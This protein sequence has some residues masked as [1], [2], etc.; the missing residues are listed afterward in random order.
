M[1]S[2]SRIVWQT[3][4]TRKDEMSYLTSQPVKLVDRLKLV[5]QSE[6]M[7]NAGVLAL[8]ILYCLLYASVRLSISSSMELD[9]AEQFLD[10]AAFHLGYKEQAPLYT[11]IYWLA[12]LVGGNNLVTLTVVKY[13]LIFSFFAIFYLLV[14]SFWG[15][16]ESLVVTGSLL[17]FPTYS[18]E[19]NRDLSHSILIALMA[20]LTCLFFVRS[21]RERATRDYVAMGI[22]CGLGILSK[23]NFAI[24]L[25]AFL[26]A[27]LS[28]PKLRRFFFDRKIVFSV[29]ACAALIA[30][31]FLWLFHENFPSLQFAMQVSHS[32]DLKV[33]S[34]PRS[35]SVI[36]A[37]YAEIFAFVLVIVLFFQRDF[38]K[39]IS[40][41][42]PA[43]LIF[44]RMAL[45]GLCLPIIG[46]ILFKCDTFRSR[47]LSTV[48]F[49]IPIAF[50]SMMNP[51]VNESRFRAFG[52]LTV[53]IA[54][55]VLCIRLV[56]GFFPDRTGKIERIHI[57]YNALS[58]Q[59]SSKL[60]KMGFSSLR[61]VPFIAD[62]SNE[63]LAANFLAEM[64]STRF[65]SLTDC[66]T[67]TEVQKTIG[68]KGGIYITGISKGGATVPDKFSSYFPQAVKTTLAST[69]LHSSKS[70]MVQ[71]LIIRPSKVTAG[72]GTI[73]DT[74]L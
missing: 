70:C 48:Y 26:F 52:H 61:D 40:R 73:K 37:S 6:R 74:T 71:V 64:P 5:L 66:L 60:V 30:P 33:Q 55:V 35:L 2:V 28:S 47:W 72:S 23:Y 10:G 20:A 44:P 17:L 49:T 68:M 53:G 31:H 24:F 18:Y 57:P 21:V 19:S 43:I 25:V 15:R 63:Y 51:K 69:C 11:W 45:L 7:G 46:I 36:A 16:T 65:V 62:S 12:S 39:S 9:E 50:F 3:Q 56:A 14:R 13:S 38:V 42:D 27:G 58:A 8:F 59:L 67:N 29:L 54:I 32:G 4:L 34:L 22:C 1:A 41:E